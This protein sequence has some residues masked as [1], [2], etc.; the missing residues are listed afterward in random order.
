MHQLCHL[1]LA[2]GPDV[3]PVTLWAPIFSAL[4]NKNNSEL[5]GWVR[6]LN[7]TMP[8]KHLAQNQPSAD[9]KGIHRDTKGRILKSLKDNEC[10]YN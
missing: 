6:D 10:L 3:N 4:N 5:G 8:V 7:E 2:V 9:E 1:N